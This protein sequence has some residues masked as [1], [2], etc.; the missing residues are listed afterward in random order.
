MPATGHI[1]YKFNDDIGQE[2]MTDKKLRNEMR[3]SS[4]AETSEFQRSNM[5]I[6]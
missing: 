5:N 6:E 2:D 4:P 1:S 3:T